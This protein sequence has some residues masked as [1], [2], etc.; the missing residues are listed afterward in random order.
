MKLTSL[1][2]AAAIALTAGFS[3]P[4]LA[5]DWAPAGDL[6]LQIGFAAGGATDVMGRVLAKVIEDQ[7]GWNVIAENRTGGG[8]I[9]MFTGISQRPARGDVI[10]LGVNMPVLI[11]LVNRGDQLPFDLDSFE[12][13]GTISKG[14][15]ALVASADA[16]FDDLTG[17]IDYAKEQGNMAIAFDAAPQKLLMDV[18]AKETGASFNLVSTQG[19]SEIIKLLLGGQVLAGF[20]AGGHLPYLETGELKV[21]ASSNAERLSYAPDASTFKEAGI[22]AYVEPWFY[23]AMKKGTDPEALAAISEAI[24]TAIASDEM[25]ETIANAINGEAI[26]LGTEG[27]RDMLVDGLENVSVLFGK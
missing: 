10:G 15:L 13:L 16:P 20:G 22:D 8:G 11:N 5:D 2:Q 18:A 3:S 6:T 7:T 24:E 19:G 9:A 27:T 23:L 14:E 26:N 21:I 17:M 1:I 25:K 4:T 12:Y